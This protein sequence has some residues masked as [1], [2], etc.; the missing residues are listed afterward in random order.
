MAESQDTVKELP[1]AGGTSRPRTAH[2]KALL[3]AMVK[4][5]VALALIS[6]TL[7]AMLFVFLPLPEPAVPEATR[8]YDINGKTVSSLFVEN[9]VVVPFDEIPE[10]LKQAV[11]AIED[12]RFYSH[13]GIDFRSLGRALVTNIKA[14]EVVEGGSTITQQL[15]WN[16]FLTH[17]RTLK[18]KALEAIYALKLEMR[19]S[20]EEILE[21]YL[22]VIY[23][24]HG[25]YGC[26]TASKLYFG[27]PAKDITLAESAMLAGIIRGPEIYSPYHNMELAEQKKALVLDLMAEQGS[28]DTA[29]AEKAK[30]EPIKLAGMPKRS[31]AYFIDF[32]IAQLRDL[33]PDVASQ[34]YRGGYE[35]FTTLDLDMQLAAEKAFARYLPEGTKDSKGITQPQG[36]LVAVEPGTGYVKALVGGR[37]WNETQ[38][39]RA[40]QVRRQPGSAFKIF[41][42]AAVLDLGHPVNETK[43]CEPVEF[44]GKSQGD[45]YKPRDFGWP[46]YHYAPLDIRQAVA[47]SDNVVA[48]RWASEIGP[49]KIIEY[50]RKLGVKSPLQANIPLALGASEVTPLEMAAAGAALSAQGLYA[51]PV[52][53]LKLVDSEGNVLF[54]NKTRAKQVLDSGTAYM[55]TSVLRSVIGP[56]GTGSGL[57]GFLGNRPAAGKT[58]TSDDQLEA[59]FVG[60]T[61]ELSC[62]VY[63]GW[64]DRDKSLSGT[65]GAVAGPVWASF[66]GNALSGKPVQNWPMPDSLSWEKV[67]DETG[68]KANITCF[69]WHYEIFRPG[70]GFPVCSKNHIF[71]FLFPRKIDPETDDS[72]IHR[73]PYFAAPDAPAVS[74]PGEEHPLLPDDVDLSDIDGED[75]IPD[76]EEQEELPKPEEQEGPLN[77]EGNPEGQE[78]ETDEG[79]N[80][81]K[82]QGKT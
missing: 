38:L 26:E 70:A 37:D 33:K 43:M 9:R 30:K 14:G 16:L 75:G 29:L 65:G 31:A 45:R 49:S 60:Y 57:Q 40:Y 69:K 6:I 17:E 82:S 80:T 58:G 23:L 28:I 13:K 62:A 74:L 25:T 24:G 50:A 4:L 44:P 72:Q 51:E 47:I 11:V 52:A 22:N 32:I 48:T 18:R 10:S 41:L 46:P 42:Y 61:K 67:C 21:M 68:Q 59:W 53:I 8:V 1:K 64:D 77:P 12:K 35:I 3:L 66:M 36:A 7:F 19:Y 54:E 78:H 79:E 27:K 2:V 76:P 71:E 73:V 15:S 55:L 34:I 81:Q 39:N 5:G 20:K 56:G 63:V